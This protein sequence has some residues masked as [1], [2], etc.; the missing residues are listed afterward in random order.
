[1]TGRLLSDH[2]GSAAFYYLVKPAVAHVSRV[3]FRKAR[4][5]VAA[6]PRRN[7]S[8][9]SRSLRPSPTLPRFAKDDK[10]CSRPQREHDLHSG[11]RGKNVALPPC[12][13]SKCKFSSG[14]S[15]P[16]EASRRGVQKFT[17]ESM[18]PFAP[19]GKKKIKNRS[20]KIKLQSISS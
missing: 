1:M 2:N 18:K 11:R 4:R 19:G 7:R 5:S 14:Q 12:T 15:I 17:K 3:P 13:F 8:P 6:E 20:N 16:I 10:Y 9:V